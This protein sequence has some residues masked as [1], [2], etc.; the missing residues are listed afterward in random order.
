M[1]KVTFC[2]QK[3]GRCTGGGYKKGKY[4]KQLIVFTRKNTHFFGINAIGKSSEVWYVLLVSLDASK[5]YKQHNMVV[6]IIQSLHIIFRNR[7]TGLF[8]ITVVTGRGNT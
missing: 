3:H 1:Y 7:Y 2:L 5:L 6:I 4:C 8:N